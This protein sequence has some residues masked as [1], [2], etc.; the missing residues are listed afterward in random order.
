M[1]TA[2]Y[3]G[4]PL[5]PQ[6]KFQLVQHWIDVSEPY[7]ARHISQD[8]KSISGATGW[9]Q[10][11]SKHAARGAAHYQR[12]GKPSGWEKTGRLWGHLGEWPVEE[13]MRFDVPRAAGFRYRRLIR[14]WRIA[15]A[16]KE[17]DPV[18]R[19]RRIR[20]ARG[21]LKCNDRNLSEVRGLSEWADQDTVIGFLALLASEGYGIRQ[22][23]D[24]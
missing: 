19:A 1:H 24:D 2:V 5:T 12:Q 9:L 4:R 20:S 10:Y 8:I 14:S 3:F 18:T 21:M 7:G 11:L 22:L 16:R 23:A 17:P 15:D 13:P 6:E